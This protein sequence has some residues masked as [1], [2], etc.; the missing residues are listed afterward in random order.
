[1]KRYK[2]WVT[3]GVALTIIGV[4][5]GC[6]T[7]GGESSG[8]ISASNATNTVSNTPKNISAVAPSKSSTIDSTSGNVPAGNSLATNSTQPNPTTVPTNTTLKVYNSVIAN[9]HYV[10]GT[11][12]KAQGS[13]MVYSSY[14]NYVKNLLT[15]QYGTAPVG[16]RAIEDYVLPY[17]GKNKKV[18][19]IVNVTVKNFSNAQQKFLIAGSEFLFN[20]MKFKTLNALH[21]YFN[22]V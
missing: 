1:M 2:K 14:I 15:R 21:Q 7:G 9:G 19:Y 4:L 16:N 3:A 6:G 12:L 20:N 17:I 22:N 13:T 11:D 18:Y 5:A 8:S 10:N